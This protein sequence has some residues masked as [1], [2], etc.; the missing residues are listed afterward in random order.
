MRIL[1][2]KGES[3][4][5]PFGKAGGSLQSSTA[6][7]LPNPQPRL[8]GCRRIRECGHFKLRQQAEAIRSPKPSRRVQK[9]R[10]FLGFWPSITPRFQDALK[11]LG[12][13]FE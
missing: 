6:H 12:C 2:P 1:P 13:R 5:F 10:L 3:L 8:D 11:M 7:T 9:L 4:V